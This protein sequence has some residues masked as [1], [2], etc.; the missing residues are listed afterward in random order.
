MIGVLNLYEAVCISLSANT[1]G[2]Y[3]RQTIFPSATGLLERRLL[4]QTLKNLTLRRILLKWCGR[5][6]MKII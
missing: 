3:M 2:K 5:I 4:I 6:S 1:L